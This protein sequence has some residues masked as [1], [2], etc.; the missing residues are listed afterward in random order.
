MSCSIANKLMSSVM[1]HGRKTV[2]MWE[3]G[4]C[5]YYR[6]GNYYQSGLFITVLMGPQNSVVISQYRHM[7]AV[8][9][10]S[11]DILY[12]WK[13]HEDSSNADHH[14][15]LMPKMKA[16]PFVWDSDHY[17]ARTFRVCSKMKKPLSRPH[18][19]ANLLKPVIVSITHCIVAGMRHGC[20]HHSRH[21]LYL[22]HLV[23]PTSWT[24]LSPAFTS[25]TKARMIMM[26][27]TTGCLLAYVSVG[28][29]TGPYGFTALLEL[30]L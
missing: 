7:Q 24:S 4:I 20:S 13:M 9:K 30:L 28:L 27:K 22:L 1:F 8:T 18:G 10:L 5:W 15:C 2:K 17:L 6:F 3:S 23:E 16:M 11:R 21:S 29:L 26:G 14:S 19:A 12:M 25:F